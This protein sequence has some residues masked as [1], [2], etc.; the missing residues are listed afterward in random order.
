MGCTT[1][2]AAP[3]AEKH[4]RMQ[5][6]NCGLARVTAQNADLMLRRHVVDGKITPDQLKKAMKSL[7]VSMQNED[8]GKHKDFFRS[9]RQNGL[10]PAKPLLIAFVLLSQGSQPTKLELLFEIFD[11]QSS[12]QISSQ[13]MHQL[14]TDLL[15]VALVHTPLLSVFPS[16]DIEM[17]VEG[18][19]KT[20]KTT[21]KFAVSELTERLMGRRNWISL[22]EF[23]ISAMELK[24]VN[25]V[26]CREIRSFAISVSLRELRT[27]VR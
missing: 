4:L 11:E 23:I 15:R 3:S 16:K 18:Y 8:C 5:E 12:N 20:L 24:T 19:A 9:F 21:I 10:Y 17:E 14:T 7:G 13:T 2:R 22:S 6:G 1:S 27:K 25:I 26:S